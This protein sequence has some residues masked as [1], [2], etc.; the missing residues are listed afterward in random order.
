MITTNTGARY[1]QPA[2]PLKSPDVA[3]LMAAALADPLGRR[4]NHF[5]A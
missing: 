1:M 4:A 5:V 3:S 2:S